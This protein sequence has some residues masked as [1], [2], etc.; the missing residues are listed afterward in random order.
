MRAYTSEEI[1]LREK[2]N[3]FLEY[4]L[5]NFAYGYG[6]VDC[7]HMAHSKDPEHMQE[8]NKKFKDLTA[9]FQKQGGF[10]DDYAH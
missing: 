1:N 8:F 7:I 10:P 5:D 9:Q 4:H 6:Y 3:R 2:L